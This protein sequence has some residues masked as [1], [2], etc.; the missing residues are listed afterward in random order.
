LKKYIDLYDMA[1]VNCS[2]VLSVIRSHGAISRKEI[3]ELIGLSWGGMT[4]IINKLLE[5]GYITEKKAESKLP[6]GRTP[7]FLSVNTSKNFV[8]GLQINKLGL[9]A[10]V[11][12]LAGNV[13]KQF[14]KDDV[15]S[16]RDSVLS[17]VVGFTKRIFGSFPKN[18]II[19]IGIAMQGIVDYKKGVSANFSVS[20][21]KDVHLKEIL[22]DEFKV[23]VFVE[24][25]TDCFLYTYIRPE[26]KE[27]VV[28]MSIDESI[29]MAVAIGGKIIKGKGL[30]EIVHN[31]VIPNGKMCSCGQKGCLEAYTKGCIENGIIHPENVEELITPLAITIKNMS[32]IFYSDR[33]ILSSDLVE[34]EELFCKALRDELNELHCDIAVEF[35]KAS[36]TASKGAA[37]IASTLSIDSLMINS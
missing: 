36:D 6:C 10:V 8:V 37:L 32:T 15:S 21:W 30:F 31:I 33:I 24:H 2:N 26:T 7:S 18:T 4:K 27:T 28:F 13:L 34:Y 9:K 35:F 17:E 25:D 5:N 19:S 16:D 12:D 29:G 23:N 22:E 1:N 20:G 11:L 14:S 3:C